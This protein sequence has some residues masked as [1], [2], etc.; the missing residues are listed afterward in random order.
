MFGHR[1][2]YKKKKY[3][4][5]PTTAKW[6]LSELFFV[7]IDQNGKDRGSQNFMQRPEASASCLRN[8]LRIAFI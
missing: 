6:G 1:S 5:P 7:D 2:H 3:R 8:S 4:P